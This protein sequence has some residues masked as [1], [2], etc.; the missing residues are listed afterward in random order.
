[1]REQLPNVNTLTLMS[2]LD[3]SCTA[4]ERALAEE[5]V[6]RAIAPP[7]K[8]PPPVPYPPSA[9]DDID[10]TTSIPPWMRSIDNL[11]DRQVYQADARTEVL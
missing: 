8:A 9:N 10:M 7:S 6:E 4:D 1:M 3:V 2:P 5:T 11:T